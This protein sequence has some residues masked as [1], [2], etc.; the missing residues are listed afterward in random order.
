MSALRLP[1]LPRLLEVFDEH[2]NRQAAL[3]LEL[4]VY[5]RPGLLQ[6]LLRKVGGDDL[7]PPAGERG[8][9]FLQAHRQR[10]GF[11]PRRAGGTPHPNALAAGARLQDYG[12]DRIAKVIERNLV[13]KKE[14]F[15]G[16]HRLDHLGCERR[17]STLHLLHEF[18][19]AGQ[20]YFSRKRKQPAFDQILLVGRQIQAGTILEKFAQ[21]FVIG[22]GHWLPLET[23]CRDFG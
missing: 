9:H 14:G 12:H 7:D 19:D 5:S 23:D 21:V 11:L 8:A 22:R 18:A 16:G 3:D 2:L 17:G 4:A 20:T 1:E 6:H 13:A 10:I 15:V